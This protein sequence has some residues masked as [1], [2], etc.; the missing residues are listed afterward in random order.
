MPTSPEDDFNFERAA[1]EE[2]QQRNET[3]AN[4]IIGWAPH[5]QGEVE[6]L[7]NDPMLDDIARRSE[8]RRL[9]DLAEAFRD[10]CKEDITDWESSVPTVFDAL[11]ESETRHRIVVLKLMWRS[12]RGNHKERQP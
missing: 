7:L 9:Q 5:F 1:D 4:H 8:L 2:L 6:S 3:V 12:L 10:S 11:T